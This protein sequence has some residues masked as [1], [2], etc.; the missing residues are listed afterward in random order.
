MVITD[1]KKAKKKGPIGYKV[2]PRNGQQLREV[3]DGLLPL[4][5]NEGCYNSAGGPDFLDTGHLLENVLHRAGYTFHPD[6]SGKLV[7]TAAFTIPEK[8]LIVIRHDVYEALQDD[9]P[10]ARYTVAHE[11]AHIVLDHAVTL[12]RNAVLGQHKWWEDSEWQAN[13]LAAELLM[14]VN[15]VQKLDARPIY[16]QAACGVSGQAA[17]YRIARLK[18]AGLI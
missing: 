15:V 3:A 5:R 4:L 11:F 17:N 8:K 13:N 2:A 12:H 18:E 7:N 6:D 9:D 1:E 16:I 14:P 10:F